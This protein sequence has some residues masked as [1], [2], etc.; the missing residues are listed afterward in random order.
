VLNLYLA[1]INT[2]AA[3]HL[4]AL[5]KEREFFIDNL[6][7]QIH[8]IIE[9]ILVDRPCAM[10]FRV[11]FSRK[12]YIYLP[13]RPQRPRRNSSS[14]PP[15]FPSRA[16]NPSPRKPSLS[17]RH[18]PRRRLT[19]C[20]SGTAQPGTRG[21]ISK[22][23]IGRKESFSEVNVTMHPCASTSSMSKNA[24]KLAIMLRLIEKY[25]HICKMQPVLN[26]NG[27]RDQVARLWAG[28]SSAV[29]RYHP[30]P[31]PWMLSPECR[32]LTLSPCTLHPAPCTLHPA[33]QIS[34]LKT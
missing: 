30:D 11:H 7:G 17:S 20:S 5:L 15:R 33:T 6:L 18:A 23:V 9:M 32:V 29:P 34:K 27:W 14:S 21:L 25:R 12:P 31:K 19:C 16:I 28:D 10:G 1:G 2:H 13:R 26:L 3:T 24:R 22:E 4:P 8:F